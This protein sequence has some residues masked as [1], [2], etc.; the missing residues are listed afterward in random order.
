VLGRTV[1]MASGLRPGPAAQWPNWLVPIGA[2]EHVRPTW[3]PRLWALRGG[4][5]A[6]GRAHCGGVAVAQNAA[7]S[8]G[9]PTTALEEGW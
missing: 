3:S 6:R 2:A 5:V 9:F 8:G 1:A 4:V 7:I